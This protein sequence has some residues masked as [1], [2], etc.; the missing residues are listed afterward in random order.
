MDFGTPAY[1]L[2]LKRYIISMIVLEA[3]ADMNFS[4][5]E[6]KYLAYAATTLGLSETEVAKIRLNPTAYEIAPPPNEQDRM[7]VLY[8]LLFMMW[9][10]NNISKE[11]ETMCHHI[12]FRLGFRRELISDLINV[13][14]ECL[15]KDIP[16]NAMLERIKPYLN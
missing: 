10:D 13:L 9:S 4:V 5:R 7:K 6:K 16:P 3:Q 2:A 14:R 1:E 11:E 15:H 8:Y 12:G